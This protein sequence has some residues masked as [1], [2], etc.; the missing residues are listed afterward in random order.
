MNQMDRMISHASFR[1][2]V[3][4]CVVVLLCVCVVAHMLGAPVTLLGLLNF[5][6]LA[7]SEPVSEDFSAISPL[8][9]LERPYLFLIFDEIRPV[10]HLPVLL[11]SVFH[12]PSA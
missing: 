12:P 4:A 7:E 1:T 3:V 8:P 9:K 6:M 5:D 10:H 11:T 2:T